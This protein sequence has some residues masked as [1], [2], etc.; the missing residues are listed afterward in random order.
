MGDSTA[1]AAAALDVDDDAE[2]TLNK[3]AAQLVSATA[4]PGTKRHRTTVVEQFKKFLGDRQATALL[5]ASF[6]L[7]DVQSGRYQASTLWS[8][9]SHLIFL[10]EKRARTTSGYQERTGAGRSDNVSAQPRPHAQQS[11]G[12]H[13]R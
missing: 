11:D 1:V 13:S 6:F 4:N 10:Y 12:I 9:R 7:N 2:A 8:R 5:A 3:Q